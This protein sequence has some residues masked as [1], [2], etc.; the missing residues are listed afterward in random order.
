MKG[1]DCEGVELTDHF[2]HS[3]EVLADVI[4]A[5]LSLEAVTCAGQSHLYANCSR[6]VLP[7]SQR[8]RGVRQRESIPTSF[9][10]TV[11]EI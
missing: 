7:I 2:N 6:T 4:V 10:R 3:I 1:K 5:H 11:F 9:W 8:Q